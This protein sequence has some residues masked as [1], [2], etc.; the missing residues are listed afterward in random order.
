VVS[1][2]SLQDHPGLLHQCKAA[3]AR[4]LVLVSSTRAVVVGMPESRRCLVARIYVSG[5]V[6]GREELDGRTRLIMQS[7][8]EGGGGVGV[9]IS[10]QTVLP[11][12]HAVEHCHHRSIS[13]CPFRCLAVPA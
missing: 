8:V 9:V 4:T 10:V 1:N 3:T 5:L 12:E 2:V 6:D 13:A 7:A 11:M